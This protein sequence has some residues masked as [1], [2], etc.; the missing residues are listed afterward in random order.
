MVVVVVV[1]CFYCTHRV[2]KSRG[3]A[4]VHRPNSVEEEEDAEDAMIAATGWLEYH[5]RKNPPP[6]KPIRHVQAD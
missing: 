1:V 2:F 3:H 5:S 4:F 6:G